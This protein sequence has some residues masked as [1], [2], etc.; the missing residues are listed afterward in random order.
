MKYCKERSPLRQ[1][2]EIH[3]ALSNGG[4]LVTLSRTISV[5]DGGQGRREWAEIVQLLSLMIWMVWGKER[6]EKA[7]ERWNQGKVSIV[8]KRL[9]N[10]HGLEERTHPKVREWRHR[11]QR[12]WWTKPRTGEER[13]VEGT[14]VEESLWEK[15]EHLTKTREEGDGTWIPLE[16]MRGRLRDFQMKGFNFLHIAEGAVYQEEAECRTWGKGNI[17]KSHEGN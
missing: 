17:C 15:K 11:R 9:K 14:Q 2:L 13:L 12:E 1:R 5:K 6:L 10:L 8:W 7:G 16:T 3:V 4:S